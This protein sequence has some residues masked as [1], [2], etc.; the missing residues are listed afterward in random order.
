MWQKVDFLWQLVM[1]SSVVG[2]RRSSKALPKSKLEQQ[3]KVMITLWW[4]TAGLIHASFPNPGETTASEKYAQQIERCTKTATPAASIG[5][6]KGRNFSSQ[7]Q[8][9]YHTT[10][11]SKVE[12]NGLQ[13]FTSSSIFTWPL[14]NQLPLL[15]ASWRLFAGK[16]FHS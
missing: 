9:I 16:C 6:Q 14:T 13:S 8:T 15:Q 5:Q 10:N 3:K 2:L 11:A 7:L 4:S 1:T 12:Q